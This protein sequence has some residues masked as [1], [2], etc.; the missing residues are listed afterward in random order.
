MPSVRVEKRLL[1]RC[2]AVFL[3]HSATYPT[4]ISLQVYQ[5]LTINSPTRFLGGMNCIP[6]VSCVPCDLWAVCIDPLVFWLYALYHRFC[7]RGAFSRWLDHAARNSLSAR[8]AIRPNSTKFISTPAWSTCPVFR[9]RRYSELFGETTLA[10]AQR[11]ARPGTLHGCVPP[12]S[13]HSPIL[14]ALVL[15]SSSW[16]G[17]PVSDINSKYA[18]KYVEQSKGTVYGLRGT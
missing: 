7:R 11:A 17:E 14:V 12:H 9:S 13:A 4:D 15:T 18:H 1:S 10:S 8:R 2:Q 5:R 3:Y 16:R 6:L